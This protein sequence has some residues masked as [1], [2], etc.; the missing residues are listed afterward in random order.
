MLTPHNDCTVP[1]NQ[2]PAESLGKLLSLHKE[3]FS[4]AKA[5]DESLRGEGVNPTL[6][7]KA[8]VCKTYSQD[9]IER[10]LAADA[11]VWL[12]ADPS[13]LCDCPPADSGST[14]AVA[15]LMRAVYGPFGPYQRG[16]G[17][18]VRRVMMSHL[19][20]V[21]LVCVCVCVCVCARPT[22]NV[23]ED[24]SIQLLSTRIWPHGALL[25]I[26]RVLGSAGL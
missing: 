19:E 15:S 23:S 14:A 5:A 10:V 24:G 13:H 12:R 7:T 26:F 1:E 4:F 8:L 18:L 20:D 17:D 2:T 25:R 22:T 6:Y 21:K 11:R 3:T 16:F 9:G